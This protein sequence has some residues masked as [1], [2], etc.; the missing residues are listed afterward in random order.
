MRKDLFG[1]RFDKG[2]MN[3]Q[4]LL[5][6]ANNVGIQMSLSIKEFTGD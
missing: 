3:L 4:R 1:I 2:E 6:T 5:F